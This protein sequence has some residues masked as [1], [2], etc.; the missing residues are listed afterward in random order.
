MKCGIITTLDVWGYLYEDTGPRGALVLMKTDGG[1][2]SN[3]LG[4][5]LMTGQ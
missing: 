1:V 4:W 2:L 3:K 5:V